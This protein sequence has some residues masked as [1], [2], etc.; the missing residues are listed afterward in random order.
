M[1]D[2]SKNPISMGQI[3]ADLF[4]AKAAIDKADSMS[5]K[6][7]KFYR[8][9][10]G[11]HLQ[12]A[13]EKMIKIQIYNSGVPVD[14]AK[15]YRHSLGDLM[16]YAASIGIQLLIPGWVD[17]KKHLITTWE[18]EGRYDLHFVVRID[19]LKRCYEELSEWEATLKKT[20]KNK[21]R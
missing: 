17:N 4:M 13:A 15:M 12:Q 1:N 3:T 14:N 5:S 16:S 10:A 9:Q 7:G 19:T 21:C 8:G 2:N 6:E 20:L 18:A 11:Y